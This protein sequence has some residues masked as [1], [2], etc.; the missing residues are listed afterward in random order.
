MGNNASDNMKVYWSQQNIPQ[1]Q[2]Y[3]VWLEQMMGFKIPSVLSYLCV[4]HSVVSDSFN[5]TDYSPSD[6]SVHGILQ[7]K[8]IEMG[9]YSL[10]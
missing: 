9:S 10:L 4:S 7:G 1:E 6:S 3:L 8:N 5:P 2:V